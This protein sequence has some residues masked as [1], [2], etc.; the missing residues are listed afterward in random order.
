[1]TEILSMLVNWAVWSWLTYFVGTRLFHATAT[2]GQLLR[3]LGFAMSPGVF[4]ILGFVPCLGGPIRL[5]VVAWIV[6]AGAI[7][8]REA[9]DCDNGR[10]LSVMLVSGGLMLVLFVLQLVLLGPRGGIIRLL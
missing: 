9:L 7:A 8:V 10:A 1:L 5:A 4:D 6:A 3:P 2:P